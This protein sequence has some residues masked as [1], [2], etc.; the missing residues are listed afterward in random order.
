MPHADAG[1]R[2]EPPESAPVAAPHSDI[3]TATAE[4]PL[5]PPGWHLRF[6]GLCTGPKLEILFVVPKAN[7][8][9][10]S[11]PSMIVPAARYCATT[12]ASSVGTKCS[13]TREQAVVRIPL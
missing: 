2:M 12:V 10:L 1:M 11:L 9:V 4:P 5:D 3:D 13:R 8:C 6:Q 7:S